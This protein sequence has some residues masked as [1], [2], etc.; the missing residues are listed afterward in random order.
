MS[1]TSPWARIIPS[2]F[3]KK[4]N[5]VIKSRIKS[6]RESVLRAIPRNDLESKHISNLQFL[7][8]RE[9]LVDRLPKHGVVAELGV[10]RGEFSEVILANSL[11]RKFHLVDTWGS[12]R[13]HDGL[14]KAVHTKFEKEVNSNVVE[15]NLG[16]STEVVKQFPDGY[17]DW[18]YID[19][20]HSYSVT[21]DELR[22]YEPK[23]KENGVIAGHD[24]A[25]GNWR[26]GIK[27][28]VMEAVYEF[29]L[30]RDWEMLYLTMEGKSSPSFA[31]RKIKSHQSAILTR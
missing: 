10:N 5:Q 18:I 1:A 31:I 27:Y 20:D 14:R 7:L 17:F 13:Y 16:L 4:I 9:A 15:M 29:C 24:F 21:A 2:P 30:K 8:D 25:M 28:G 3:R 6:E 22:L 12:E 11:P 19:T 26:A 23:M